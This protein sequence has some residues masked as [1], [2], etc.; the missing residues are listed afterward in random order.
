MF[1]FDI[2]WLVQ[3]KQLWALLLRKYHISKLYLDFF[4]F[5]RK[6]LSLTRLDVE[7]FV[8]D[9]ASVFRQADLARL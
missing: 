2:V 4:N 8:Q 6:N 5:D 7:F 3:R 1:I 9:I